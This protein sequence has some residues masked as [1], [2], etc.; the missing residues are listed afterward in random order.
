MELL[1]LG[2]GSGVPSKQRNV[3]SVVLKMLNEYNTM[4]MFDCGE[5]TQHQ[6]L[7]T[8]LKPRKVSKI[9]ITHLHGDHIFGLPGFLSSRA[10]Q[11][12]EEAIDLY[13][14]K[15]IKKYVLTSLRTSGTYLKYRLR[16]HEFENEEGLLFKEDRMTVT[17][18]KLKHGLPSYGFRIVEADKQGELL[19]DKLQ[20]ERIPSGPI[21][22]KLKAGETV[23]LEDGRVING[24]DYLGPTQKGK[25]IT[26]LGDTQKTQ[27]SLEL[28]Q[29]ADILVHE[30]TFNHENRDLAK[31]YN[32]STTVEAAEV[33]RAASVKR[34]LLTHISSRY[35]GKAARDLETEARTIFSNTELMH[36]FSE[37]TI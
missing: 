27:A 26:I 24:K 21:Y 31:D 3:S 34:L 22:G 20:E 28:A 19:V 23:E 9:F 30:S 2:T 11:G 36:D 12:G 33:A 1:F 16:F 29:N 32:H 13:G 17:Y 35:V 7:K 14:P 8:T 15:G 37:V 4:W 5:G 25:I 10:F 6:I 18:K